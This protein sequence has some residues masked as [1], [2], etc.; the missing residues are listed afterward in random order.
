MINKRIASLILEKISYVSTFVGDCDDWVTV[1]KQLLISL[2]PDVRTLF[3]TRHP[4]T[5][6]QQTNSFEMDL[7]N[8]YNE[9]TGVRLV[10]RSL[11]ERREL[12]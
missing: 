3:S 11:E 5:K 10:I 8:K 12:R 2:P 1:K 9:M 7:M 6:E 4:I